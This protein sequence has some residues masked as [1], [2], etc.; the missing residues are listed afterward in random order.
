MASKKKGSAPE[1]PKN[2]STAVEYYKLKTQAVDDLI[3]ADEENSPVVS[4]EELNRYRKKS[5]IQLPEWLKA[6]LIKAWFAGAVCFF[7]LWGLG[8]Y[9]PNQIDMLFALGVALGVVNDLLV[10]NIF[11]FYE[12]TP[13]LNDRWMM[14]PKKKFINFFFNILYSFVVLLCVHAVYNL[15]NIAIISITG[16]VDTVPLGVEPLLFGTLYMGFDMLFIGMKH[17]FGRIV[18]DAKNSVGKR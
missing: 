17:M 10:N 15:V 6:V 14:F 18:S 3:N 16:A 11:R 7:I 2:E 12:S 13:G 9:L 8:I 1:P 4:E 5:K